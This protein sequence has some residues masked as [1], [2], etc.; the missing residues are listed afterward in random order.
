[1]TLLSNKKDEKRACTSVSGSE[2]N[3]GPHFLEVSQDMATLMI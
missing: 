3:V 1:M 2:Y